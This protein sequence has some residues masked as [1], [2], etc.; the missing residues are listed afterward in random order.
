MTAV[1]RTIRSGAVLVAWALVACAAA[2]RGEGLDIRTIPPEYRDDYELFASR[3]SRCHSLARPVA[4]NFNEAQWRNYV[5][6]M[7]R[8]PGSGIHPD[9]EPRLLRFLYWYAA[10]RRAARDGGTP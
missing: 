6:R 7:R 9:D 5:E 10:S 4:S 1:R 8:Q 2:Q 3:C